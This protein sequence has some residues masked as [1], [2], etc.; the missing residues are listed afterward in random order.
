MEL[1]VRENDLDWTIVR[2]PQLTD[3]PYT[4]KYRVRE[5][6]LPASVSIF[7]ART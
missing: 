6:H 4:G 7:C 5:R 1:V 2:P 3:K